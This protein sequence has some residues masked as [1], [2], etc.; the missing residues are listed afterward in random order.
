M[1]F[2]IIGCG[3]MGYAIVEK[4][5]SSFLNKGDIYI[6]DVNNQLIDELNSKGYNT[7]DS[8]NQLF[9]ICDTVLFAV[10][11]QEIKNVISSISEIKTTKLILSI[12]AGVKISTLQTL[13]PTI[14][15]ARIMP[16]TCA[17]IGESAS[18][19]C[20]NNYITDELKNVT[21]NIISSIGTYVEIDES[22]MDDIIP[23]GGSFTAYA[24]AFMRAF[25]RSSVKR[26][27][28]EEIAT[29]MVI[30]SMIGSSKMVETYGD[31]DTLISNVCSKGGTTL[32]GLEKLT[33]GNFDKIIDD[34]AKACADR[35][36]ELGKLS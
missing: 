10:K 33:L 11:P 9:N 30:Q 26:G 23:I 2:G 20:Y 19:I 25:I 4:L 14:A 34:C 1:K 35:S 6:F 24:Y 29:K 15:I 7:V 18:S 31:I 32:A 28:S 27:I 36:K 3:K 12:M 17:L 13:S 21:R 22:L 8:Y 16:N 5:S